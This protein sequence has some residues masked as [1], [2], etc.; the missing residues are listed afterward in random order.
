M[1]DNP[2]IPGTYQGNVITSSGM[3]SGSPGAV[4]F[5]A[6]NAVNLEPNFEAISS[7]V[8]TV[9]IDPCVCVLSQWALSASATSYYNL[10]QAPNFYPEQATG[11][12]D[13]NTCGDNPKAWAPLTNA[14]IPEYL[15]L[16]YQTPVKASG[17]RIYET[18]YQFGN[19]FVY[20]VEFVD[21]NDQVHIVWQG[22]D[23]VPCGGVFSPDIE[24]TNYLVKSV[25]VHTQVFGWEEIDAV[26]LIG[27]VC[28]N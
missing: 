26:E 19:G 20:K 27:A 14:D 12:P 13:V 10:E 21:V 1:V 25:I 22:D 4:H 16:N 2:V 23:D 24:P 11:A 17:V 28:P 15:R 8:F 3:L 18:N 9:G 7:K 6:A 5:R